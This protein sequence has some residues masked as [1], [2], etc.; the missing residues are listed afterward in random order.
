MN[1][2][3]RDALYHHGVIGQ[4]WG[5]RRYQPYGIGYS[6]KD[7]GKYV[8]NRSVKRYKKALKKLQKEKDELTAFA[9]R[10]R[11]NAEYHGRNAEYY[12]RKGKERRVK[13]IKAAQAVEQGEAK[14]YEEQAKKVERVIQNVLKDAEKN[15]ITVKVIERTKNVR[16]VTRGEKAVDAILA[17]ISGE[18]G[19]LLTDLWLY[20]V[21]GFLRNTK[22]NKSLERSLGSGNG[23]VDP[24][25]NVTSRKFKVTK[26]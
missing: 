17:V 16:A 18:P 6:P 9:E 25:A 7:V 10:S 26:K 19:L 3:S 2:H 23:L 11:L 1:E 8:G 20:P 4:K 21:E 15:G 13:K 14:R 5:I 12:T 24:G 22:V